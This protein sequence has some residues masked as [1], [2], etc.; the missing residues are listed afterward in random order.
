MNSD[1]FYTIYMLRK[2]GV[3]FY[4]LFY[5]SFHCRKSGWL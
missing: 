4:P 2:R 3:T 5:T 1:L